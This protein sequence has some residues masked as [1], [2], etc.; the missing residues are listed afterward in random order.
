M[1]RRQR[2]QASEKPRLRLRKRLWQL[3]GG[4]RR[5]RMRADPARFRAPPTTEQETAETGRR[6]GQFLVEQVFDCGQDAR[7]DGVLG[8]TGLTFESATRSVASCRAAWPHRATSSP[9]G[10]EHIVIMKLLHGGHLTGDP[11]GS[12]PIWPTIWLVRRRMGIRPDWRRQCRENQRK[13]EA[14]SSRKAV[15]VKE[16]AE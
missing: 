16:T 6:S 14:S 13:S 11:S 8:P 2:P 7:G 15:S 1:R 4:R 10:G 5:R 12:M 3:A 9:R